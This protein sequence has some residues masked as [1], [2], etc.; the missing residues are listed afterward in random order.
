M[1]FLSILALFFLFLLCL[2]VLIVFYGISVYNQLVNLKNDV[3]KNWSNIDVILVQR[4]NEI[5]KLIDT[6]KEYMK[7]EQETLEK[8]T[9]ARNAH[10]AATNANDVKALGKAEVDLQQGVRQLF[11]LAEKYPDL[12]ANELFQQLQERISELESMLSDKRIVYNDSVNINNVCVQQFPAVLVA[13][14]FNFKSFDLLTFDAASKQDVDVK[15][16]F[17]R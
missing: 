12:K 8:V 7:Y 10:E 16:E 9:L 11:A 13:V 2:A 5:T 15:K 14:V 17:D 4:N 1:A 6:C 3:S